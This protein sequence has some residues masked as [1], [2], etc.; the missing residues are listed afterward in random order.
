MPFSEFQELLTG[1]MSDTPLGNMVSIRSE[2]NKDILKSFTPAMMEERRK[3]LNRQANDKLNNPEKLE[4]I[5]A[6]YEKLF[7]SMYSEK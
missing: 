5:F 1:L 6:S 7:A 3:W 4:Q 2:T